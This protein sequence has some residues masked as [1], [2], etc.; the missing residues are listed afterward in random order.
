MGDYR[1]YFC[2]PGILTD[3]LVA[4]HAPD[5]GLIFVA[6]ARP[7]RLIRSATKRT[8]IDKDGGIR[9]L[10]FAIINEKQAF[11]PAVPRLESP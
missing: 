5:H 2:E 9:Y 4:K 11:C 6:G 7:L 10:R 1:F 3:E 8:L